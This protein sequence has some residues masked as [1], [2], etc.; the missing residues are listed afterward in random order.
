MISFCHFDFKSNFFFVCFGFMFLETL[1]LYLNTKESQLQ[2]I[3]K[4]NTGH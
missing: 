2:K 3:K 4:L 1:N